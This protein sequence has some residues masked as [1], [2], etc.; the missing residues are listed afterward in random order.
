MVNIDS[1]QEFGTDDNGDVDAD[2]DVRRTLNVVPALSLSCHAPA[3]VP[4]FLS[5]GPSHPYMLL[6]HTRHHWWEA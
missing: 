4:L 1:C 6:F 3:R 2:D 5:R